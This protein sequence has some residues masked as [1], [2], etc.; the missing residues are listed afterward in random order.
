ML[1]FRSEGDVKGWL[2][3]TGRP[4]GAMIDFSTLWALVQPWYA[5]RMQPEW[6]GLS[7]ER[8]QAIFY[9]LGLDGEWWRLG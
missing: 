4:F 1:A 2:E 8:G 9:D 5:G 7:A 3:R 6:R